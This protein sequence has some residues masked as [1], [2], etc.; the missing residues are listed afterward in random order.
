MLGMALVLAGGHS[1]RADDFEKFQERARQQK[2]E[3]I[4]KL[5][6]QHS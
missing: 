6:D 3:L 2:K 1:A 4:S 5:T